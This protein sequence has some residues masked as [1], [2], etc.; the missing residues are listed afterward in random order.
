MRLLPVTAIIDA[1]FSTLKHAYHDSGITLFSGKASNHF[2]RLGANISKHT[3]LI[4]AA[5]TALKAF[6]ALYLREMGLANETVSPEYNSRI[7][8]LITI[9]QELKENNPDERTLQALAHDQTLKDH[10]QAMVLHFTDRAQEMLSLLARHFDPLGAS[11]TSGL[12]QFLSRPFEQLHTV[13]KKIYPEHSSCAL[14]QI[15]QDLSRFLKGLPLLVLNGL[16]S[17]YLEV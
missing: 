9:C 11:I 16:E 5:Q 13:C 6:Y 7:F 12:L 15:Q 2:P 4:F 10:T 17:L 3:P 14:Q 8:H 1:S